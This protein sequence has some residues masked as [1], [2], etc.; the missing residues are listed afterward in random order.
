MTQ[1]LTDQRPRADLVTEL[2]DRHAAGLFAYCA[3][4][5][6]DHGSAADALATV[7]SGV[8]ATAPPRAALYAFARREIHRRDVVYAPPVVDPLTD[9]ASALVERT[10]RDLRPHQR[11]V[12]LLSEVCRLGRTELAWVLDVAP[13]TA[14]E[15]AISAAHRYR[16]LLGMA[17]AATGARVP[18]PVADVYGALRVAPLRDVLG[19]LPWPSPPASLRV[20]FAGSRT[21]GAAP[22]F[23]KPR[24]PVPPRW[25]LPLSEPDPATSTAIFPAELLAPPSPARVP[26]HDATTAPMPR[27][28]DPMA[29]TDTSGLGRA[30]SRPRERPFFLS[31]PVRDDVRPAAEPHATGDVLIHR[32]PVTPPPAGEGPP[33]DLFAPKR[34][35]DEPVYRMPLPEEFTRP[36]DPPRARQTGARDTGAPKRSDGSPSSTRSTSR[37]P[38]DR[39][40]ERGDRKID[41]AQ[42]PSGPQARRPSGAQARRPVAGQRGKAVP[43]PGARKPG[44]PGKPKPKARKRRRGHH[45]WAWELVGFLLCVAIAMIVFFSMPSLIGP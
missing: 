34:P 1:P 21:A 26:E 45:D 25:P 35:A 42:R 32:G 43:K 27:L 8:S 7:L 28:R 17:L 12:L 20:H 19:R 29:P 13:D 14:E 4:Q 5:L 41:D 22:M 23:V 30:F 44:K 37:P 11:E 24:W 3:D 33:G 16:Q 9:P 10:L 36:P 6:G 39:A 38:T 2:Y 18:K 15:L 40:A 31:A